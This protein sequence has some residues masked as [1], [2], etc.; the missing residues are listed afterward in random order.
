MV[1]FVVL[2]LNIRGGWGFE[3]SQNEALVLHFVPYREKKPILKHV[4]AIICIYTVWV[5]LLACGA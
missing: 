1:D 3:I 4:E 5:S 2:A